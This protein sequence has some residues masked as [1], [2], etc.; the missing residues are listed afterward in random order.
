MTAAEGFGASLVFSRPG[1]DG[2]GIGRR[3]VGR[4]KEKE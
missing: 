4:R 2:E 1:C 3:W